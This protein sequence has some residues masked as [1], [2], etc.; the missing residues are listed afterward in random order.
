MLSRYARERRVFFIEEPVFD[1]GPNRLDLTISAESV[2]VVVPHL[3]RTTLDPDAAQM[4]L[5]G[6]LMTQQ[7]IQDYVLW[8]YT[9]MAL[10]I[11]HG[12]EP[13]AV[14]YDCMDQLA[15]FKNAPPALLDRER[16]LFS[17]ADVVFT[18]G[19]SLY[20]EKKHRHPNVHPFP[21]SVDVDHFARAR[22]PQPDPEDQKYLPR[23]RLGFYGVVDER[24]DLELVA[25]A[26]AARPGWS[27]VFIGPVV[28]IED[29]SLPRAANIHY[30]GG[31]LYSELPSYASA[32]DVA[33][34]PF[35]RNEST[36]FIS[37]TKTPEYLAA[38]LPVV[39]TS[40]RDVCEPYQ[41]LGLVRIADSVPEFVAACDA[42]LAQ[43]LGPLLA[44]ADRFLA[45]MSWEK[46]WSEMSLRVEDAVQRR[47][48]NNGRVAAVAAV[49]A[50]RIDGVAAG[51]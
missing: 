22:A 19:Y 1:D 12:L 36:R 21:S 50:S 17:Q 38:G 4:S 30:L 18:G 13:L 9:P 29:S 27:F 51:E 32:W 5:L 33:L 15:A 11:A 23:P 10:P 34:L 47:A 41:K 49:G 24:M 25:G 37:P 48:E 43:P 20:E 2:H 16:A 40:I 3:D 31:K 26:A 28:K 45:Q 46:T 6:E 35:A 14:V 7:P 44:A 39:S 8:Y 42:A